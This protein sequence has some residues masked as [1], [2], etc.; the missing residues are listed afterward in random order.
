MNTDKTIITNKGNVINVKEYIYDDTLPLISVVMPSYNSAQTITK[1]VLSCINQSYPNVEIII[2]D[3]GSA[4]DTVETARAL[5][6]EYSFIMPDGTAMPRIRLIAQDNKGVSAARNV[7]LREARGEWL[8][9]LDSDDYYEPDTV[10]ILY[11]AVCQAGKGE[12]SKRTAVS[13]ETE[14]TDAAVYTDLKAEH[15]DA[16]VYTD[17]KAEPAELPKSD[18][19]AKGYADSPQYTAVSICGIRKVWERQPERNQDFQPEAFAGTL[20]AFTDEAMTKLYDLNLIGTH[21]NK[22]Y[23]A[24]LIRDK[25]IYYNEELQVNED[26]DFVLRYLAACDYVRVVPR[27]F[28]NYVQHDKG[29]SLINTFQPHGLKGALIVLSSCNALF[30]TAG[31]DVGSMA[32]MDRRMFVHICSFAGLMYYRSGYGSEEIKSNL[33]QMRDNSDFRALLARLK[34]LGL[35]DRLAHMLLRYRLIGIYDKICRKVYKNKE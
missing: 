12:L 3:N 14:K 33:R 24:R 27:V 10:E 20:K 17:S 34:P 28:L 13:D 35:K 25:S 30:Q 22:L 29:Q 16:T 21:S 26:L 4:D 23:S 5:C 7:G 8:M 32:A 1:A 9:S 6:E 2:I 19:E 11:A 15:T 31:T 18:I